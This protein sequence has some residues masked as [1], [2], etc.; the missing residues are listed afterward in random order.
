MTDA[1]VPVTR[2]AAT[3][4]VLVQVLPTADQQREIGWGDLAERLEDRLG[5]IRT[6]IMAGVRAVDTDLDGLPERPGWQVRELSAKFGVTL[7]AEAGVVLSRAG[8]ESTFE[9]T[10]TFART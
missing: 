7:K 2:A 9:V 10:V 1:D 4:A 3:G 6:A 5:E 8:A